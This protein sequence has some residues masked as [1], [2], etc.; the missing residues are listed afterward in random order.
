[1]IADK[2]IIY[3]IYTYSQI[4]IMTEWKNDAF[5]T[6]MWRDELNKIVNKERINK[7][8]LRFLLFRDENVHLNRKYV[9]ASETEV[10]LNLKKAKAMTQ[11][12]KKN[13]LEVLTQAFV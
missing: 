5:L 1:M 10:K 8:L 12:N 3:F 9:I 6:L 4:L 13:Q 2:A 11:I 7:D